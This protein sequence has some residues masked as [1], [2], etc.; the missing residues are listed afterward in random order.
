VLTLA[1]PWKEPRNINRYNLQASTCL[2]DWIKG[3]DGE[4]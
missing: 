3:R 4:E 2:F 1:F